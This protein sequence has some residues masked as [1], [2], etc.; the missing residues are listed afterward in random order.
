M[1]LDD[2]GTADADDQTT[3][4]VDE[5]LADRPGDSATLASLAA[6]FASQGN[7]H[8]A[9]VNTVSSSWKFTS[10]DGLQSLETGDLVKLAVGYTGRRDGRGDLP[11]HSERAA[12]RT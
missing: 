6:A 1:T 9:T 8:L 5:A 11:V 10:E 7:E 12:S 4:G 3:T 2:A